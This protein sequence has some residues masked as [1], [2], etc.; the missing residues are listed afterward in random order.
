MGTFLSSASRQVADV[1]SFLRDSA[2]GNSIKYSA[3]AGEKH[4]VYI[5]YT[6]AQVADPQGN[7]MEQKNIIAIQGAVHEW[8]NPDGKFKATICLKDVVRKAEDGQTLLN[9][10][11]CPFCDRV[12]DAWDIYRYRKEQEEENCKLTGEARKNHL[13]KS[14]TIFADERKS[15]DARPYMYI[16]IV[17][18]RTDAQGHEIKGDDGLPEYDLKVMKLSASRVEK[19]TQQLENAGTQ[20]AGSEIIFNYPKNEDRR[21]VVSQSTTSPVFPGN[22]LLIR[23]PALNEKI[24]V[25]VAKFDWEGIEKSFPE[26]SGMT[27]ME[28]KTITDNLFEKWD[29]YKK[30]V[31]ANPAAKYLEY[32]TS[33]PSSLPNMNATDGMPTVPQIGGGI[34]VVPSVEQ[35]VAPAMT[36]P[37][38][39]APTMTP[40]TMGVPTVAPTMGVPTAPV[41][42]GAAQSVDPNAMFEGMSAATPTI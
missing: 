21:L 38:M 33:T 11:T 36:A 9:D 7:A 10:G 6:S 42:P 5:P 17:K 16:L 4:L 32:L 29:E 24:K 28:A 30:D 27:T 20:L 23:Y 8:T 41:M 26:W 31:I 2:G 25:D 13:E 39:T 22:Q 19:I 14:S 35:N 37:T 34:P 18:F 40:P 12:S 1:R 3:V 15:K